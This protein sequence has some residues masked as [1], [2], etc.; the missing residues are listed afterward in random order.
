MLLPL[1]KEVVMEQQ[2]EKTEINWKEVLDILYNKD[3]YDENARA[4]LLSD[5]TIIQRKISDDLLCLALAM[6]D[7]RDSP[8]IRQLLTKYPHNRIS[9]ETWLHNYLR[10]ID[11]AGS[12]LSPSPQNPLLSKSMDQKNV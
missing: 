12:I 2:R 3:L 7:I 1:A 9:L 6:Q 5:A 11:Q 10:P 8:N 4:R